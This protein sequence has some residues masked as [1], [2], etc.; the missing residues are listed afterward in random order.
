MASRILSCAVLAAALV[1][2][3]AVQGASV[4]DRLTRLGLAGTPTAAEANAVAQA[5]ASVAGDVKPAAKLVNTNE[6]AG[7]AAE[8]K[9]PGP[10]PEGTLSK[11]EEKNADGS[12]PSNCHRF[13]VN[14]KLEGDE[15]KEKPKP[16]PSSPGK[17]PTGRADKKKDAPPTII[18][19]DG[20]DVKFCLDMKFSQGKKV[21][22]PKGW[23]DVT[24][25]KREVPKS[26]N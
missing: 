23:K 24:V 5:K 8:I 14:L 1:A 22:P 21:A 26:L 25:N 2:V 3:P 13:P 7:K 10:N 20:S 15:D 19:K 6:G 9:G 12:A 16:N 17:G 18:T 11:K 4:S